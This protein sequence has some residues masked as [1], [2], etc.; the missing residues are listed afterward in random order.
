MNWHSGIVMACRLFSL[1][2]RNWHC[3]L[4]AIGLL[5][6]TSCLWSSVCFGLFFSTS[7]QVQDFSRLYCL[8]ESVLCRTAFLTLS[9][10][11]TFKKNHLR[12]A[13]SF[14]KKQSADHLAPN[15]SGGFYLRPNKI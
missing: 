1:G 10:H 9:N 12:A 15:W 5:Q 11:L 3:T 4:Y 7:V 8:W 2:R 14:H 6:C 13:L